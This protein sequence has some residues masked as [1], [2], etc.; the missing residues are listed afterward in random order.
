MLQA[1][2]RYEPVK[3][4]DLK[5][6]EKVKAGIKLE[7]IKVRV[8]QYRPVLELRHARVAAE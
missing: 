1:L 3:I 8:K 7:D 4:H 2:R 5:R 6:L